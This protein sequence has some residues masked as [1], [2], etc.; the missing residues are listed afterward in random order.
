VTFTFA[1]T[2][3]RPA[4]ATV[5][6]TALFG[7]RVGT[8]AASMRVHALA[9]RVQVQI[10]TRRRR[11]TPDEQDRLYEVFGSPPGWDRAL[12]PLVWMQ[13]TVLTPGFTSTVEIDL[14]VPCSYDFEV[15]AVKYLHALRDGEIPLRFLFSGTAFLEHDGVISVAP[16]AWDSEAAFRMPAA[17]WR[18]VMDAFFPDSAWIRIRRETLDALHACR[19]RQAAP[20]WDAVLTAL[21]RTAAK[22]P[23]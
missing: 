2:G 21:L 4:P 13:T 17:R 18:D 19:G 7:L 12:K 14:P 8:T 20:D 3:V 23:V 16:V 1:I 5:V 11:Y 10:E 15:A 6:P 22:E 9:L